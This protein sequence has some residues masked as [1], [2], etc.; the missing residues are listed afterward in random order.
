SASPRPR[1]KASSS[2]MPLNNGLAIIK[3][4]LSPFYLMAQPPHLAAHGQSRPASEHSSIDIREGEPYSPRPG[5]CQHQKSQNLVLSTDV[6][7]ARA[8]ALPILA[9]WAGKSGRPA[10]PEPRIPLK[11]PKSPVG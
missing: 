7:F 4:S 6:A 9:L 11:Y 1:V 3:P 8:S 10:V 5:A 2:R